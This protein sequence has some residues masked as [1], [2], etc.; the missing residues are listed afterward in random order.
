MLKTF[1]PVLNIKFQPVLTTKN[2]REVKNIKFLKSTKIR[3]LSVQYDI[4]LMKEN[5]N[6]RQKF[7]K[8]DEKKLTN[9][10]CCVK[11]SSKTSLKSP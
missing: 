7:K 3:A 10:Y 1:K 4:N 9:S 2:F 5:I 6:S 11:I 8:Y